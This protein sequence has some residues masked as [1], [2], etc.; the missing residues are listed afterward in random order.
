MKTEEIVPFYSLPHFRKNKARP[1]L[2]PGF[3]SL[4]VSV[5]FSHYWDKICQ[6]LK[7]ENGFVVVVVVVLTQFQFMC[8]RPG[9][10]GLDLRG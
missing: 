1:D 10:E 9:H 6:E 5:T 8:R 4:C 7:G 3:K 2:R